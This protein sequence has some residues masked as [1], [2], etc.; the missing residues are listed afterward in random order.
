MRNLA[1]PGVGGQLLYELRILTVPGIG[2]RVFEVKMLQNRIGRKLN[3]G[4]LVGNRALCSDIADVPAILKQLRN[5]PGKIRT[6]V[7]GLKS[8]RYHLVVHQRLC[9]FWLRGFR[10][11]VIK[12]HGNNVDFIPVD[13]RNRHRAVI[14][15]LV[16][17]I[18]HGNNTVRVTVNREFKKGI[19]A[20]SREQ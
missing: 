11:R 14:L 12:D 15:T 18:T 16:C 4:L 1:R 9:T 20:P 8:R 13:R 2:R 19:Q 7:V 3:T 6:C 10:R 5:V 17:G